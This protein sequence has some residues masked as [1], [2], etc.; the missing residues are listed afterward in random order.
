MSRLGCK[1]GHVMGSTE[2]PS[3]YSIYVYCES[4]INNAI[5]DNRNLKVMDFLMNWDEV[6][7]CKKQYMKRKEEVDYWYCTECKRVY[8]CQVKIGGHWLRVYRKKDVDNS[9]PLDKDKLLSLYI[10]SE[11]YSDKETED[12]PDILLSDFISNLHMA[13]FITK[14]EKKVYA[15]DKSSRKLKYIYELE[16]DISSDFS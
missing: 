15:V 6:N 7:G 4:E 5:S 13:Y 9:E 12:N 3:P 2:S 11:T 16:E 8:E 10:F 14:D 1:C